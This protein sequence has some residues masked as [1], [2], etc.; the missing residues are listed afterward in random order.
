MY[1]SPTVL[2]GASAGFTGMAV[3]GFPV[4]QYVVVASMLI[5]SGLL[6]I[7]FGHRRATC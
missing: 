3:T 4:A 6:L 2:I 1:S 5:V 7:R